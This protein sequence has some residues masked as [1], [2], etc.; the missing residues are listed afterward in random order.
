[1][2]SGEGFVARDELPNR[3]HIKLMSRGVQLGVAAIGRAV[4]SRPGYAEVPPGRRGL[5]VGATPQGSDPIELQEALE[6]A[7]APGGVD[8]AAFGRS[9]HLVHP[10]WLVRG[11]S[12]N[13][14]GYASAYW[15][16]RGRN[17]SRCEGRAG[18]LAA[19]VEAMRAVREGAVDL[20]VAG[21]ADSL[22]GME[23]WLGRP[24][25]EGA[26]FVVLEREGIGPC[27]VDGGVA[28]ALDDHVE[29]PPVD[30]GPA[31]GPWELVSR[32]QAGEHDFQVAAM[33]VGIRA[34]LEVGG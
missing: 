10:L 15:D 13:V 6:A 23:S 8:V 21:G 27:L 3:K 24:V 25:G 32:L 26:A 28:S 5:F 11:L 12:N 16:I 9:V 19:I 34:W 33:D 20:A 14:L 29:L 4:A 1:V 17:G 30:R 2:V 18:G 7:S 31:T 22:L